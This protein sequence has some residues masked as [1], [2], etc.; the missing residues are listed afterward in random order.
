MASRLV[1]TIDFNKNKVEELELY[2]RLREFSSPASLIK[3]ILRLKIS[4]EVLDL[5]E[6]QVEGGQE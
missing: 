1:I 3:D 6:N 4:P 2:A 5:K